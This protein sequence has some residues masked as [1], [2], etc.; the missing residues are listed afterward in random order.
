VGISKNAKKS[1][2]LTV[3]CQKN[4]V[5]LYAADPFAKNGLAVH[6]PGGRGQK[7]RLFL[8]FFANF[9]DFFIINFNKNNYKIFY[10]EI[11]YNIT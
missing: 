9:Y 7:N 10:K 6:T 8:T 5:F 1:C 4:S 11:K 2:F 3:F